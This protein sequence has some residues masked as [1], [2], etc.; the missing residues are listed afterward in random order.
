MN[1][2]MLEFSFNWEADKLQHV[3]RWFVLINASTAAACAESND[4]VTCLYRMVGPTQ[5]LRFVLLYR[6]SLTSE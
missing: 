2:M 6:L 3:L 5:R 4:C 1:V